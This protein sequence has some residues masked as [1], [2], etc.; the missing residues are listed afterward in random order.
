MLPSR[1][2]APVSHAG[3]SQSGSDAP[4]RRRTNNPEKYRPGWLEVRRFSGGRLLFFSSFIFLPSS[5]M[6][7]I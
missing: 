7:I 1:S 3:K 6:H 4:V 5:N 2:G